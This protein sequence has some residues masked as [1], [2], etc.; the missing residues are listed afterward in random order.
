[1]P[2]LIHRTLPHRALCYAGVVTTGLL[3]S[4]LTAEAAPRW[5]LQLGR[6]YMDS[7]GVATLFVESVF[8][9]RS[10]GDSRFA[11]LPDI[12]AGWIDGRQLER[13]RHSSYD[14]RDA[15]WLAAGGVRLHYGPAGAWYRKV[16]FSFQ[17]A[18]HS[19]RTQSLSS[20][21]EFVS[22]L[23]W[24]GRRFSFMVRHISNGSTHEPNRGETMA[25]LGIAFDS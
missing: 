3:L 9:E 4:P 17:P 21:Y 14:T 24:E 7:D 1:M 18:L 23:G 22:T 15:A 12:S 2:F 25:L 11:W 13:Y 19:G 5:E 6:S 10:I 20:A 16:F 8:S